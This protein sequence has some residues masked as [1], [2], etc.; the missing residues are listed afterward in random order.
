MAQQPEVKDPFQSFGL[1]IHKLRF[2]VVPF[3]LIVSVAMAAVF[4]PH[5][6]TVLKGG[7]FN[8]PGSNSYQ[9]DQELGTY[10]HAAS[11]SSALIVFRSTTSTVDDAAYKSQVETAETAVKA[12]K[13]VHSA[14]SYYDT[15]DSGAVS[16]DKHTT[17]IAV[18][19]D[20]DDSTVVATV[21]KIRDALDSTTIEHWVTGGA[22]AAYD[23]STQAQEDTENSEKLTFPILILLL[24]IV[25]GT[26]VSAILPLI[27]GAFTVLLT[28]ALVAAVAMKIDTAVF[29]LSVGSMLG[30]G[31]AIDYSLI[32]VTRFRE[33][34]ALWKDSGRALGITM[35][36]AGRSIAYSGLT[37][38]LAMLVMTI[39]L[40]PVM[41]IRTMSMSVMLCA[42]V[43]LVQ[44]L[45]LL[46]A[47]LSL[48]GRRTEWLRII[49]KRK[50][51][52]VGETGIW[53]R[54][55]KLVM[56]RP[57]IWL[58]TGLVILAVLAAPVTGLMTAG[59]EAPPP[60]DTAK[61]EKAL[62]AAFPG[63]KLSPLHIVIK[64]GAKDGIWQPDLLAAV[65]KL[66]TD[67][68]ADSRVEEVNSLATALASVPDT[69]FDKLTASSLGQLAPV[70]AVYVNTDGDSS[71][72][73]LDVV[74]KY[75]TR[76]SRSED[77]LL[78]I[79]NTIV[80]DISALKSESV[81]VGGETATFYDYKQVIFQR[82]P[83]AVAVVMVMI[84]IMLAMFF[85]S[86]ALPI[87][88]VILNL[89]SVSA[90]FGVLVMVF[91]HGWAASLIHLEPLGFVTII[92]PILLY[93]ILFALSTDYEVFMLSRVKEYFRNS[94]DNKE[95]VSVGLQHT[96][97]V[98]TAAAL[99]LLGTFGSFSFGETVTVKELGVGLAVGVLIDAT[100]V[101]IILVPSSMALMGAANWWMPS[102][103]R[104]ILPELSEGTSA[105]LADHTAA[106]AGPAP[107]APVAAPSTRPPATGP[108]IL[109]LRSKTLPVVDSINATPG[110][111]IRFGRDDGNE[112]Q[113]PSPG[114]SRVHARID[115]RS[116]AWRLRDLAS[117]NG[118]WVNG[119]RVPEGPEGVVMHNGDWIQL[120]G[121]DDFLVLF[122]AHQPEATAP[123]P[124]AAPA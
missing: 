94:G 72:M 53:Y 74:S 88:A 37:V 45:T 82:F 18:S 104:R 62:E 31:L 71:V 118:T 123:A 92:S 124:V 64:T 61:G 105:A 114:I 101:R 16:A 117:T 113:I 116:G 112:I 50:S 39:V 97:G 12:V 83:L 108:A 67:L 26:L 46:P 3:W 119:Q 55:A 115:F 14:V 86:V 29:A 47:V 56:A 24:I 35:A 109:R 57:V 77:L 11:P 79:R 36:T 40:W 32:I 100:V 76:D 120:G 23:G 107:S 9:A 27:L 20:G 49:P 8:T 87:K 110:D 66:T 5:L 65:R 28:I 69:Q 38:I 89:L 54:F 30:L 80:P 52:K 33:E 99:I 103:L 121:L 19:I 2:F 48:L 95:A 44:G 93:V 73:R 34:Y 43:A 51:R 78:A 111:P 6:A 96:A 68:K 13:N 4:A 70:A 106:A 10:F 81:Y 58:V 7:G 85:Q 15:H 42:I 60:T 21:P 98:I 59:P 102:W 17:F 41:L 1:L 91:Q 84:L 25:F 22:P 90:T 122:E 63:N 75:G